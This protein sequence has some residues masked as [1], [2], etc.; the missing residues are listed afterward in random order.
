MREAS[1][2]PEIKMDMHNYKTVSVA[3][4]F[5][6][7]AAFRVYDEFIDCVTADLE[8]IVGAALER[9]N[10]RKQN[11]LCAEMRF[12]A[13]QGGTC[14]EILHIGSYDEEPVSFGKLAQFTK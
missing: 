14:I 2:P 4:K 6:S 10:T 7:Q 13:I 12:D 3:L 11:P 5:S 9:V 1:E 8:N